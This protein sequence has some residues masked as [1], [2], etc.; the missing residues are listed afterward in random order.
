MHQ[1]A[2]KVLANCIKTEFISRINHNVQGDSYSRPDLLLYMQ[3]CLWLILLLISS[4][5]LF[6]VVRSFL[7][8]FPYFEKFK[9]GLRSPRYLCDCICVPP[10]N[11]WMPKSIIIIIIIIIIIYFL[12]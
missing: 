4:Q 10:D 5:S 8:D 9:V 2:Y 7:D 3:A 1:S 11:Y 12:F 6:R